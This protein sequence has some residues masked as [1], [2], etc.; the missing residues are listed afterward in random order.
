MMHD[1]VRVGE[2]RKKSGKCHCNGDI[3]D[4]GRA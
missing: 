1:D 2:G 3:E 4:E